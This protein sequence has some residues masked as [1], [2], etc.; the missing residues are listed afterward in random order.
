MYGILKNILSLSILDRLFL[1]AFFRLRIFIKKIDGEIDEISWKNESEG[2]FRCKESLGQ[3]KA[4]RMSEISQNHPVHFTSFCQFWKQNLNEAGNIFTEKI[5]SITKSLKNRQ[6]YECIVYFLG[7]FETYS[8]FLLVQIYEMNYVSGFKNQKLR[9][10]PSL[11][12]HIQ[13]LFFFGHF[14]SS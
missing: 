12:Q 5:N 9:S 14:F 3:L 6:D 11:L 4:V 2:R 13:F 7:I 1:F 8:P 10:D